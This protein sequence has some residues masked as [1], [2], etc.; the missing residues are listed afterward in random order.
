MTTCIFDLDGV[1]VDTAKYH[2]LAWKKLANE[3]G[4]DLTEKMNERLKGIGRIESLNL[5]LEMG[6]LK[7]SEVEKA[8]LAS[9]KNSWFVEYIQSMKKEEIFPGAKGLFKELREHGIKVGLASSSKNAKTVL[10]LLGIENEFEAVVDGTMIDHSKPNP[11]IFLKAARM[12]QV[13]PADCIVIE[14]AEAGVEAALRAG[15][16]CVG[17]GK[18]AQLSKANHVVDRIGNL[19]YEL[20]K[21]L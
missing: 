1:I 15:M 2:Y 6:K 10:K 16:R 14:D 19:N 8:A 13:K 11:E 18:P 3:L 4:I 20:L 9:K 5:I 21:N 12:L 7:M 17:I